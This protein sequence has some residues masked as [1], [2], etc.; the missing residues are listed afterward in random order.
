M[1]VGDAMLV[2]NFCHTLQFKRIRFL[3]NLYLIRKIVL[4]KELTRKE[5]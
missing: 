2:F 3:K 4:T 5:T 1:H